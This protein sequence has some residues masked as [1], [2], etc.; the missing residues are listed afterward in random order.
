MDPPKNS[1]E[2]WLTPP[3]TLRLSDKAAPRGGAR[4]TWFQQILMMA[5]IMMITE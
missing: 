2:W 4:L 5:N 1:L 3:G